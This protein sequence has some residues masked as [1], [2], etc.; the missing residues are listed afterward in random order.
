MVDNPSDVRIGSKGDLRGA[1]DLGLFNPQQRTSGDCR[2]TSEK[3]QK[4]SSKID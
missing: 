4:R 1:A 2:S 3:C